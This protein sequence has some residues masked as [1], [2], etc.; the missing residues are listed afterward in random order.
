MTEQQTQTLALFGLE[1]LHIL[2]DNREWS[3]ETTDQISDAAFGFELADSDADG[4]FTINP[5]A[6]GE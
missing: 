1:V 3:S 4:M 6:T 2:Q 5:K